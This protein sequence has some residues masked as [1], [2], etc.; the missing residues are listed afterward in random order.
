MEENYNA[1]VQAIILQAVK[2]YRA[3]LKILSRNPENKPALSMKKEVEQFFRSGWFGKLTDL[4]P[5]FLFSKLNA[6]V[7]RK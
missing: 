3:A 2:D 1:L 4:N 5:E 6:E 7:K